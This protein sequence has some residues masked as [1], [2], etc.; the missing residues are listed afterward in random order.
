MKTDIAL[1]IQLHVYLETRRSASV[2]HLNGESDGAIPPPRNNIHFSS[3]TGLFIKVELLSP[4]ST[5]DFQQVFLWIKALW[6][7][8]EGA[9]YQ[10]TPGITYLVSRE[11]GDREAVALQL[12]S[13]SSLTPQLSSYIPK[14]LRTIGFPVLPW[15]RLSFPWC[16]SFPFTALTERLYSTGIWVVFV[17][18][19]I[20][21]T[22]GGWPVPSGPGTE[23]EV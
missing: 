20:I 16:I 15:K 11:R 18:Y 19:F 12:V 14:L 8:R 13:E 4:F 21:H 6:D 2:L 17:S 22:G 7:K 23:G 3:G 1:L 9:Y 5:W 10:E